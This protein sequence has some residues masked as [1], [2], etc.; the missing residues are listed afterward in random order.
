MVVRSSDV[1]FE[2]ERRKQCYG[3]KDQTR[4][5]ACGSHPIPTDNAEE[6]IAPDGTL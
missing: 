3:G 1:E 2:S 4:R 6:R 5:T